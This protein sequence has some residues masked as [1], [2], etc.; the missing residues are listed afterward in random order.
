MADSVG[1]PEHFFSQAGKGWSHSVL[2]ELKAE[3]EALFCCSDHIL[4]LF[5][6]EMVFSNLYLIIF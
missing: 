3:W 1:K 5:S 4:I 2:K 6:K